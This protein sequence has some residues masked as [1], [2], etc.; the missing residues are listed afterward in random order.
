MKPTRVSFLIAAALLGL[1]LAGGDALALWSINSLTNN[2]QY[3]V[4]VAYPLGSGGTV[5]GSDIT[6]RG[7]M[8]ITVP[9]HGIIQF[10]D[11]GDQWK[12]A[13][14]TWSVFIQYGDDT[15]G[16]FYDGGGSLDVTINAD[17]TATLTARGA[18]AIIPDI[19]PPSCTQ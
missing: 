2:Y 15:W 7:D 11:M 16:L 10:T 5:T 1:A 12:C 3:A 14:H 8:A 6:V 9:G 13:G 4:T 18:G 19:V 17:G